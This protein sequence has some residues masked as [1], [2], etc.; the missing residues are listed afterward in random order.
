MTSAVY[1][2]SSLSNQLSVI[3]TL[4]GNNYVRWKRDVEIA[5]GLLGLNFAMEKK[6]EKPTD[7]STVEYV[8]EHEKWE[9]ANK[10]CLKIIKRSI[11][12]SILGV[13]SDNEN[14]KSF[15]D[16]IGENFVESDKAET[17]DLMDKLMSM[18]YDG[19]NGDRE[20]AMKMINISSK[21]KALDIPI[22]EPFL[23]YHVLNSL[24]NKFN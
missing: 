12:D 3:E 15:M 1:H 21:L 5:L 9:R 7:K 24:P 19:T 11:S 20:H 4:T 18:R 2:A 6:L 17:G 16:A 8:A 23:I 14:V 10:L 22:A 13:I